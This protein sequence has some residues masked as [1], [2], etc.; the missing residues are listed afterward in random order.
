MSISAETPFDLQKTK[1]CCN[2]FIL[3]FNIVIGET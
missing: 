2:L 1:K 3:F